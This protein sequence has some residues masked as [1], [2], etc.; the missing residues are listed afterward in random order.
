M[1]V[2]QKV[3]ESHIPQLSEIARQT[4]IESHGHSASAD[5]VAHYMEKA[6]HHEVLKAEL[7][8]P[9]C[10]VHFMY[11]N[12]TLVGFSKITLNVPNAHTNL[13]PLTKLDRIYILQAYHHLHLGTALFDFN[14][15]LAQQHQQKGLWLYTWIENTKAINFYTKKGFEIIGHYDFK[16]SETHSNPNYVMLLGI[17]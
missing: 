12:D 6:Y 1:V 8:D 15:K 16:I 10:F 17:D 9:N 2:I 7:Q 5:D 4:F 3:T 11:H 14:L 13:T